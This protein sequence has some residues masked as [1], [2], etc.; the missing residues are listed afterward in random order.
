[1]RTSPLQL[2]EILDF[3]IQIAD[4]FEAAHAKGV[5]HRDIQPANVFVTARGQ[6]KLVDYGVAKLTRPTVA[7]V[8]SPATGG[9][10]AAVTGVR[11]PP[12]RH[13][14]RFLRQG[15]LR[16]PLQR[17]GLTTRFQYDRLFS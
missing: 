1:M 9:E 17:R 6:A 11:G 4:A 3:R 15:K 10:D 8:S 16:A 5:I 12:K 2:S 7:P 13:G 14:A